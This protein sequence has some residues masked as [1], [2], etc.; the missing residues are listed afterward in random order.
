[1]S[2]K[3]DSVAKRLRD[4][5]VEEASRRQEQDALKPCLDDFFSDPIVA[6]A[7]QLSD[8]VRLRPE[9][10][11]LARAFAAFN[12]DPGVPH[13][14]H[15]LINYLA[16]S[17]FETRS[18]GAPTTWTP[19]RRIQLLRDFRLAAKKCSRKSVLAIAEQM[20]KEK[21]FEGRY[22][23]MKPDSLRRQIHQAVN[24]LNVQLRSGRH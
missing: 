5:M 23:R 13:Y 12:L 17:H 20:L 22:E 16:R 9:E 1:V 2:K 8:A 3:K 14:W 11:A 10:K 6:R 19:E 24:W 18:A 7:R 4:L 15:L 21:S